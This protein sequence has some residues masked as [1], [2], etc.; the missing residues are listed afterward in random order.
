[1][2][3]KKRVQRTKKLSKRQIRWIDLEKTEGVN[4]I[5]FTKGQKHFWYYF[6]EIVRTEDFQNF[7]YEMRK[8]YKIPK[9][10]YAI[11][12]KKFGF[13]GKPAL[14]QKNHT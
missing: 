9:N 14:H 3:E 13:T 10:G 12:S 7:I 2:P 4:N 5:K 6:E 11:N 1:M 8:K